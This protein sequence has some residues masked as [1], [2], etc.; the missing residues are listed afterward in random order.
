MSCGKKGENWAYAVSPGNYSL[1]GPF[2][3]STGKQPI[4]D[5]VAKSVNL[6]DFSGV[7][8]NEL[9]FE[10]TG[11]FRVIASDSCK[12]TVSHKVKENKNNYFAL[13]LARSF[14]FEPASCNLQVIIGTTFYSVSSASTTFLQDSTD[15]ATDLPFEITHVG[16]N[17]KM[18]TVNREAL[19]NVWV[20]Y[21][22]ASPDRIKW[23][24]APII[25]S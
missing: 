23:V 7:T 10:E 14:V 16:P 2:C 4:Y 21:G 8:T 3:L 13:Q 24:L 9:R 1:T 11:L 15:Q 17:L 6:F 25:P 12:M 19:N 20:D 22:C 18:T 5:S